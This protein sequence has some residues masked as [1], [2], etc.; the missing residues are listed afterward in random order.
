MM[1]RLEAIHKSQSITKW[2][3]EKIK[4]SKIVGK[5]FKNELEKE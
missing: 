1:T 4:R 5:H 2:D 3:T